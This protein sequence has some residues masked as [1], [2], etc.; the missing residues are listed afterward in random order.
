MGNPVRNTCNWPEP[1]WRMVAASYSRSDDEKS[2]WTGAVMKQSFFNAAA[3]PNCP[4]GDALWM[5][6]LAPNDEKRMLFAQ[7]KDRGMGT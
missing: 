1:F 3:N 6:I 4:I 7:R 2:C 5:K